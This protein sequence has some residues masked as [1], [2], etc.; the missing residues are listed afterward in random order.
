M[1]AC[2]KYLSGAMVVKLWLTGQLLPTAFFGGTFKL[3]MVFRFLK[4]CETKNK[5]NKQ[6]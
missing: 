6:S 1:H 4:G 2:M 5:K 3:R